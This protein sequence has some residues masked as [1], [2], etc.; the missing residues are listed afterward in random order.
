MRDMGSSMRSLLSI[1]EKNHAAISK[2]H[3]AVES[4]RS[5][6]AQADVRKSDMAIAAETD[7]YGSYYVVAVASSSEFRGAV[8][9][10]V[11][12]GTGAGL[13][14]RGCLQLLLSEALGISP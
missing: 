1:L 12:Q 10:I 5:T 13:Q 9:Q 14:L 4:A 2:W 6:G 11:R 8:R 3:Q 7:S